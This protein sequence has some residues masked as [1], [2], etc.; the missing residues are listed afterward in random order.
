M[1]KFP[2]LK[3]CFKYLFSHFFNFVLQSFAE[4]HFCCK[5]IF[6]R[7]VLFS[8]VNFILTLTNY[9][10]AVSKLNHLSSKLLSN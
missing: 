4:Y 5:E 1:E 2:V 10:I 7:K 8:K 6:I 3:I 9:C